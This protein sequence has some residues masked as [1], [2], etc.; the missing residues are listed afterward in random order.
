MEAMRVKLPEETVKRLRS[1]LMELRR[2][3][4]RLMVIEDYPLL[5]RLED[6]PSP[7]DWATFS[8]Y[9]RMIHISDD[10]IPG[11]IRDKISKHQRKFLNVINRRLSVVDGRYWVTVE[12]GDTLLHHLDE[13]GNI[14]KVKL[15][16]VDVLNILG[17]RNV[18]RVVERIVKKGGD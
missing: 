4:Q 14:R 13:R 17:A 18:H 15:G 8:S 9:L 7:S 11:E 12:N 10:V 2:D 3:I 6:S 5:Q 16:Y 1:D